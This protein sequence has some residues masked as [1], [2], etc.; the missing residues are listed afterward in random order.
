MRK[1]TDESLNKPLS[2]RTL[3]NSPPEPPPMA[4]DTTT[5][6]SA[7]ID[8]L[9]KAIASGPAPKPTAFDK[10]LLKTFKFP[11]DDVANIGALFSFAQ[12]IAGALSTVNS[13]I[14]TVKSLLEFVGVLKPTDPFAAVTAMFDQYFNRIIKFHQQDEESR[15]LEKRV[16]WLTAVRNADSAVKELANSP[17]AIVAVNANDALAALTNALSEMLTASRVSALGGASVPVAGSI[18]FF[19][20][21]YGYSAKTESRPPA[22]WIPYAWTP[23]MTT[24]DGR[25]MSFSAS[26]DDLN[27]RIWDPSYYLD[28]LTHGVSSFLA[29][30]AAIEPGYRATAFHRADVLNLARGLS[31]FVNAWRN[32]LLVT[33]VDAFID[34]AGSIY[35]PYGHDIDP[36]AGLGI[37]LGVIDP[38]SGLAAFT[39]TWTEGFDFGML[40]PRSWPHQT[41]SIRNAADAKAIARSCVAGAADAIE[42]VCGIAAMEQLQKQVRQLAEYGADGSAFA[43]FDRSTKTPPAR[44]TPG[45]VGRRPNVAVEPNYSLGGVEQISLGEIG[46]KAGKPN[47]EYRACRYFDP[48]TRSV[49]IPLMRRMQA[50]SIRVGYRLRVTIAGPGA[51]GANKVLSEFDASFAPFDLSSPDVFPTQAVSFPVSNTRATLYDVVQTAHLAQDDEDRIDRGELDAARQRLF[52]NPRIGAASIRVDVGFEMDRVVLHEAFIGYAVIK[53]VNLDPDPDPRSAFKVNVAV[54]EMARTATGTGASGE[55]IEETKEVSGD[56]MTLSVVPSYVIPEAPY[57]EDRE[58]GLL[59]LAKIRAAALAAVKLPL[60]MIPRP[61][62]SQIDDPNWRDPGIGLLQTFAQLERREP[63]LAAALVAR[64]QPPAVERRDRAPLGIPYSLSPAAELTPS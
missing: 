31:D 47:K 45:P 27:N 7:Q 48:N 4:N 53:I 5:V 50:T 14:T 25:G 17:A 49:R 43:R 57:F 18:A 42:A 52:L 23:W 2:T 54:Y 3:P 32:A 62:D 56:Q 26:S 39:P 13:D 35:H 1:R 40:E 20:S 24:R 6:S 51:T 8:A 46:V 44:V 30:L 34:D 64:F 11:A 58:L 16:T 15:L 9:I 55:L 21:S 12:S 63:K 36:S 61:W 22:H 59:V 37:P 29:L 41:D 10:V 33:N 28:V 60:D 19:Q 38:V